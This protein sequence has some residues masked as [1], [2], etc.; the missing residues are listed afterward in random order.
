MAQDEDFRRGLESMAAES[1][2]YFRK[3][4]EV[5]RRLADIVGTAATEDGQIKVGWRGDAP[6]D[7]Q[8]HPRAMRMP[9]ADLAQ[10]ILRLIREAKADVQRRS[11]E[12]MAEVYGEE[13]PADLVADPEVLQRSL[14]AMRLS[15]TGAVNESMDLIKQLQRRLG[16]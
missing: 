11:E 1:A 13:N 8:I 16:K 7:L 4:Q 5:R 3:A 14:E 12:I 10:T 2:E 15:F 6:S 9:S